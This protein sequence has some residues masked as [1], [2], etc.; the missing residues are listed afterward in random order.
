MMVH[1]DDVALHPSPAHLGDEASLPLAALLSDA[2]ICACIQ[3][4]PTHTGLG[5]LRQLGPVAGRSSLFPR[6]NCAILLNLFQPVEHRLIP[7]VVEFLAAQII[8]SSLH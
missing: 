6:R 3:L 5:H 4:V 8:V 1:D 7:E 2:S